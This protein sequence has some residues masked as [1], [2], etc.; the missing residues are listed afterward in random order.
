LRGELA[1]ELT[2]DPLVGLDLGV[3][4]LPAAG[5]RAEGVARR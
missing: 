3:Q 4:L 2:E 5:D 1:G